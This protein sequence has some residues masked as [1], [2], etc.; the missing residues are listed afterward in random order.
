MTF[1]ELRTQLSKLQ[2]AAGDSEV[3]ER[4]TNKPFWIWD[5]REHAQLYKETKGQC[6]FND[7]VGRPIKNKKQYPLFDYEKTIYDVLFAS[8][9]IFDF[10]NKHLWILKATGLGISELMLRM[11]AWSCTRNDDFKDSQVVIVT[12]PNID[13]AV[14][15]MRRLK[16]IFEP[17]LGIRFEDKET[18]LNLNGCQIQAYPS[19]H[20][21]SFCPTLSS[22]Y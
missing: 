9:N 4:L 3:F 20:I 12:G 13:L 15:L 6:C 22:F 1:K 16:K 17:R 18:V 14:G 8:E 11:I 10:K 5:E 2:P 7:I 19:N 21:D